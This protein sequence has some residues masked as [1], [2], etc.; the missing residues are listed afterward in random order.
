MLD[1]ARQNLHQAARD[2]RQVVVA[3]EIE[4]RR[5]EAR[6]QVKGICFCLLDARRPEVRI[7]VERLTLRQNPEIG[8]RHLDGFLGE[9]GILVAE[10]LDFGP[11]AGAV[12]A[13]RAGDVQAAL[14]VL[15]YGEVDI[16][17]RLVLLEALGQRLQRRRCIGAGNVEQQA[18]GKHA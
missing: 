18:V 10:Q 9:P 16:E 8:A 3:F 11:V 6:V 7:A 12:V 1:R 4:Q 17:R 13:R 15:G 2:G 5:Y 14:A